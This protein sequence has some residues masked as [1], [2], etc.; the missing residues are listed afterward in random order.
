MMK[1][2]TFF[3][4]NTEAKYG[5]DE[6]GK[7][8]EIL[9]GKHLNNG[10]HMPK[11]A[12]K[13]GEGADET[14]DRLKA[15]ADKHG[16]DTYNKAN[17]KAKH[18]ANEIRK[19]V[20]QGGRQI[21]HVHWTSKAGDLHASTGIHASQKE[22]PSDI[23]V[24]THHAEHG[25]KH[26]GV[27]LKVSDKSSKVPKSSLGQAHSGRK[28][29]MHGQEHKDSIT[30][31]H[32]E[33]KGMNKNQ[34]KDWA[35]ANPHHHEAIKNAN[36][37]LLTK[38]AKHHARELNA[39]LRVGNHQKVADHL[40]QVM[41]AHKTPME[42]QGHEHI[43]ST[44]WSSSKGHEHRIDKPGHDHDHIF[45]TPHK[46]TVKHSGGSVNFYHDG[47]KVA[48]QSHKFDSQSDPLSTLKSA[49]H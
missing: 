44:A 15:I 35:K 1:F 2:K 25:V 39:H 9:V 13:N 24:T 6:K 27:S 43:K 12:G 41:H 11:H 30:K 22:D 28:T 45:R 31:K 7:L 14:H 47:K 17:E 21:K 16:P 20:S 19:H 49:G 37:T 36:R 46:I 8:H 32:P 33:L 26:H 4:E 42:H 5:N 23:V 34:R 48:T 3:L 38:V 10:A 40:R 18:A 29:R